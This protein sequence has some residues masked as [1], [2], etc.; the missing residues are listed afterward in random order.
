MTLV[1]SCGWIEY[2]LDGPL[3]DAFELHLKRPDVLV[4]TIVLFEV[5]KVIKRDASAELAAQAAV[6][7][8]TRRLVP[9][10]DDIALFAADLCLE[11]R[12][13]L[14]DAIVYATARTYETT[15]ITSDYHFAEMPGVEYL[16]GE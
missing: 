15:L 1:D 7:M 2:F 14:A 9:L 10:S 8:K 12:L 11:H 13:A 6:Q 16:A 4:P 3:A 5:Y